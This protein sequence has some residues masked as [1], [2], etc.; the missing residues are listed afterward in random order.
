MVSGVRLSVIVPATAPA[1]TLPRCL[2][3]IEAA[4]PDELLVADQ[5][6]LAT[7]AAAR[8]LA[9]DRATGDVLV[10][11]DADV[12]LHPDALDRIRARLRDPALDAVF[13]SYD[14]APEAPGP[15][16]G[17]RN[18]LHHHVHHEGAGRAQSFWTGIGAVRRAAFD[19]AGGLDPERRWLEDVE[20]GARLVQAGARIELD[21]AI[22]GTHLKRYT[23]GSML[24]VDTV[25]RAIPWVDLMLAGRA[26]HSSLNAGA[27]HRSSALLALG[28]VGAAALRRPRIALLGLGA[29]AFLNAGLYAKIARRRGRVEAATAVPLHVLHHVSAVAAIPAGVALHVRRRYSAAT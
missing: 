10:F 20:L 1:P 14:D 3:A 5:P 18:L 28:T 19:S 16:S 4:R 17:F 13:G 11:V 23:L 15:V 12:L 22:Q 29:F 9:A 25:E 7:P 21:P 26:P 27:R 6:P 24:H 8:N 2:A